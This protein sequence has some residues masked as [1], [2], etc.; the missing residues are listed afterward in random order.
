MSECMICY[1]KHTN[2]A[3][4]KCKIN[5]HKKCLLKWLSTKVENECPYCTHTFSEK[6]LEINNFLCK[7]LL[8]RKFNKFIFYLQMYITLTITFAINHFIIN[9]GA[10]TKWSFHYAKPYF[11]AKDFFL[12]F[13]YTHPDIYKYYC[14]KVLHQQFDLM[15]FMEI[16]EILIIFYLLEWLL[17]MTFLIFISSNFFAI[18]P[19]ILVVAITMKKIYSML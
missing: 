7:L 11:F 10:C 5:F 8:N 16:R 4:E 19:S 9:S 3:C 13:I 18:L 1:D 17:V 2:I 14:T 15:Y 6:Q 12:L